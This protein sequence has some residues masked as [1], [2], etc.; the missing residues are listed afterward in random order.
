MNGHGIAAPDLQ[1]GYVSTQLASKILEC[2]SGHVFLH[3]LWCL[4]R[5]GGF[6]A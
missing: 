2:H 1:G 6:V 3:L 5:G 4:F